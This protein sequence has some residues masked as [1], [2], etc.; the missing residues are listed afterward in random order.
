MR[1]AVGSIPIVDSRF[2]V[3]LKKTVVYPTGLLTVK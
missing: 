3:A 2:V 1:K